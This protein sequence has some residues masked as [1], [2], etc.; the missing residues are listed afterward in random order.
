MNVGAEDK[1]NERKGEMNNR[2][3]MVKYGK[4][5]WKIMILVVFG[6]G[7]RNYRKKESLLYCCLYQLNT[8][9]LRLSL[10]G[11]NHHELQ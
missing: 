4:S 7:K 11:E 1:K 3:Y 2:E 5:L 8:A 9:I 6:L 10:P